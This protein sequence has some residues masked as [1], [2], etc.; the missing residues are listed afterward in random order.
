MFGLGRKPPPPD[1]VHIIKENVW[2][3]VPIEALDEQMLRA[4]GHV[5][6]REA[7]QQFMAPE[8]GIVY[9]VN[10]PREIAVAAQKLGEL[11]DSVILRNVFAY[12]QTE[13]MW[14]PITLICFGL[15]L[16]VAIAL[17]R[18]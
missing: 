5:Y 6:P 7:V 9:A 15:L 4:G 12:R 3:T 2:M 10:A 13:K 11:M 14:T 18:R 16:V 8:G 17:F 1:V